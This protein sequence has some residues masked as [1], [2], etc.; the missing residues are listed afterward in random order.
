MEIKTYKTKNRNYPWR[1]EDS[2]GN[3]VDA[4]TKEAAISMLKSFYDETPVRNHNNIANSP[5]NSL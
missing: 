5:M 1:A 3:Y 4:A 2:N